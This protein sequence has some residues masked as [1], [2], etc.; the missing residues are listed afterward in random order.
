MIDTMLFGYSV[1]RLFSKEYFDQRL[2]EDAE[3]R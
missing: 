2:V 1:I 3:A